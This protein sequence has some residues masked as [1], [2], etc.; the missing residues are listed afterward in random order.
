MHATLPLLEVTD[1]PALQ[2]QPLEI[3]QVNLGYRCNLSCLHCHVNAG[4]NRT[5]MMDRETID[6]IVPILKARQIHTL[7]LT[8]GAPE[9][10]DDFR[11]LVSQAT[12]AGVKVIDRCNLTVLCEPGQE[13]L[14]QFLAEHRVEIVASMPCYSVKNVDQQRG[15]GVFDKSITGLRLL[16]E[17]GYGK[18]NSGL[19]LN[20]VFNPQGPVLPPNQQALEADYRRELKQHFDIEFN[21][22]FVLANMP[23]KR[24]GST[25]ISKGQFA[26]YMQLLKSHHQDDN[27]AGVMCR[28]TVSVDWQG[29]LFDCDFNQQLEM[30]LADHATRHLRDLLTHDLNNQPVAVADHCYG[31]TAGQGSSCGGAL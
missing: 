15:N 11:Y 31:C 7:D 16:N 5:E 6:L 29:N 4:P 10:H 3:L 17:L 14:A 18:A 2:R 28:T 22:L 8:G 26:D 27:L 30:P 13:Q 19:T 25:L 24:F 1:F 23:I 12:A 9:L 20:L 21:Q